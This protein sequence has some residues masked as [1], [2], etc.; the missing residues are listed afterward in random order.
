MRMRA[1]KALWWQM[2]PLLAGLTVLALIIG[3]RAWLIEVQRADQEALF[4]QGRFESTLTEVLLVLQ[5]AETGQR[6]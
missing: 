6:G 3:A 5:D 2:F 1:R 4:A